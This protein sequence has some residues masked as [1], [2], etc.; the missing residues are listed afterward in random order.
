[1]VEPGD[2]LVVENLPVELL[3]DP[4]EINSFRLAATEFDPLAGEG[5]RLNVRPESLPPTLEAYLSLTTARAANEAAADIR[6]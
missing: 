1:M 2:I 4:D 5:G 3:A 6:A